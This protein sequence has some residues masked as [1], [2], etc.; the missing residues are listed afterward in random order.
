MVW[1][2]RA[3]AASME[4]GELKE[5]LWELLCRAGLVTYE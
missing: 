1:I 4:F 3:P 5:A 2:A